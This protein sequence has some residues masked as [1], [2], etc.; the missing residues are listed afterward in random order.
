MV[1]SKRRCMSEE[2]RVPVRTG[3][4]AGRD[5]AGQCARHCFPL[6]VSQV[7]GF[8]PLALP[9][10]HSLDISSVGL[11]LL[12]PRRPGT[13]PYS[14]PAL[15][16]P[17]SQGLSTPT[18]P[19]GTPPVS[20]PPIPASSVTSFT[21]HLQTCLACPC[22]EGPYDGFRPRGSDSHPWTCITDVQFF[23]GCGH[24]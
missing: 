21:C 2:G 1:V 9:S 18:P 10:L 3:D 5:C 24:R 4:R 23:S 14:D 7:A 17:C 22:A 13:L 8:L 12:S 16:R 15:Q 19:T 11:S 6:C 20:C